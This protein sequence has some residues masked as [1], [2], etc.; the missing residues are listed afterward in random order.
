MVATKG[1]TEDFLYFLR[2]LKGYSHGNGSHSVHPSF[3]QDLSFV[4]FFVSRNTPPPFIG[5]LRCNKEEI[6]TL[7]CRSLRLL[8]VC[9]RDVV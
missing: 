4:V 8:V 9:R 6:M 2:W 7:R 1:S 3:S 5:L